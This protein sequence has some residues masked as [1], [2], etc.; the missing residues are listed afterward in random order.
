V[1]ETWRSPFIGSSIQEVAAFVEAAPK[2]PKPLCKRF[3]AVLQKEQYEQHKTLLIYKILDAPVDDSG[4]RML[5][6]VPCP[7]HLAGFFFR[8]YDRY[9]WDQAVEEQALYFNEGAYWSDDDSFNQ[10][11]ALIVL[12]DIPVEVRSRCQALSF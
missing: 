8:S 9:Y 7:V 4:E 11:M 10:L 5:Q 3:F 12:D 1:K 2:P 6:K